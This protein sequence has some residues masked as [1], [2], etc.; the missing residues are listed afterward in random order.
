MTCNRTYA[1]S[2]EYDVVILGGG[3]AGSAT[4]LALSVQ[5]INNT[6]VVETSHYESDRVGESVPPDTRIP[7]T[8]LGVL[9]VARP[10]VLTNSGITISCSTHTATAGISTV[11]GSTRCWPERQQNAE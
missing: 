8:K 9:A 2:S 1:P 6:L 4:A 10:G 7:L 5:G 11:N 3:P